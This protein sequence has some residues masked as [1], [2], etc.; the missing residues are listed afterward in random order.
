MQREHRYRLLFDNKLVEEIRHI[1]ELVLRDAPVNH[2]LQHINSGI[3]KKLMD[4]Y[5]ARLREM[6]IGSVI[7][8]TAGRRDVLHMNITIPKTFIRFV[9]NSLHPTDFRRIDQWA[10]RIKKWM[11]AGIDE[12]YFFMHMHDEATSP[13]LT[14]Y[15]V[16]KLNKECGLNLI[17][18]K[19]IE[20]TPVKK[21]IQKKLFD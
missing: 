21:N 15:L 4:R 1:Q 12:V 8:D 9:G 10:T 20:D 14:V 3:Y 5:Y 17:K 18:P 11:D 2:R 6:N 7:T 16:D 19:F 13:E